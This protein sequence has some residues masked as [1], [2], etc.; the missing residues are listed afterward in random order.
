MFGRLVKGVRGFVKSLPPRSA[1]LCCTTM[2]H[3]CGGATVIMLEEADA[4][5]RGARVSL[6]GHDT[7]PWPDAQEPQIPGAKYS[8]RLEVTSRAN[9]VTP[10]ARG[11]ARARMEL[12]RARRCPCGRARGRGRSRAGRLPGSP[13]AH[14]VRAVRGI[15][16]ERRRL[17][18]PRPRTK[19]T[20]R[21]QPG[22]P[23]LPPPADVRHARD[24]GIP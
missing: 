23:S 7:S 1:A 9:A 15:R 22:R 3:R 21:T 4:R 8:R 5:A 20:P 18:A 6:P 24:D 2:L 10:C 12:A 11:T 17:R 19:A 16:Q 14:A 13:G